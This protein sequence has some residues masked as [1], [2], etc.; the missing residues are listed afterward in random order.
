MCW[1]SRMYR[2]ARHCS[3]RSSCS[4]TPTSPHVCRKMA[5]GRRGAGNGSS[6]PIFRSRCSRM[7]AL[8]YASISATTPRSSTAASRERWSIASRPH[9]A[10][11]QAHRHSHSP[12][13]SASQRLNAHNSIGGTPPPHRYR[14]GWCTSSSRRRFGTGPMRS[15]SCIATARSATRHST[16]A[17]I[18]SQP[19]CKSEALAPTC[20][21]ASIWS[22]PST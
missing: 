1:P 17:R 3:T 16:H 11:S 15:R 10:R 14:T 21:L 19:S 6:R 9:C 13:S 12:R 8:H 22:V 4:T 18:S 2:K 5:S 7:M 20:W